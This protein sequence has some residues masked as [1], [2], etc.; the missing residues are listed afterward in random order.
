MDEDVEVIYD[1][2]GFSS[3]AGVSPPKMPPLLILASGEGKR[4]GS[5]EKNKGM[6]PVNGR[7]VLDHIVEHFAKSGV[8]RVIFAVG[9]KKEEVMTYFSG[10]KRYD[11][12]EVK[13]QYSISDSINQTAGEIAKAWKFLKNEPCFFVHYGDT[14]TNINVDDF[15]DAH[16]QKGKTVTAPAMKEISTDSGVYIVNDEGDLVSFHE[17]PFLNDIAPLRNTYSNVP[18]YLVSNKIWENKDIAIGKDF[19]HDVV[20]KLLIKK[21]ICLYHQKDLWHF[22]VGDMKK[23]E[24]VCR[25][26]ENGNQSKLRKLG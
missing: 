3:G 9:I 1:E 10:S 18:I 24:M 6:L 26:Y 22:D 7:P 17:K 8:N 12:R 25:A 13:F 15:V 19:N 14:L 20:P 23:Y 4:L 21:E 16:K 2:S 5:L 11:S